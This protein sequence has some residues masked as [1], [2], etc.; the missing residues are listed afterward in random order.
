MIGASA[1]PPQHGGGLDAAEQRWGRHESGWLDLSTGINPHA[2]PL[3]DLPPALWQRLPDREAEAGLLDA[4]RHCYG[5]PAGCPAVAAAGSQ[6]LIGLLPRLIAPTQVL[7]LGPTYA[8]HAYRWRLVGHEVRETDSL[9][10]HPDARIV[11]LANPNNP[12]GRI[13]PPAPLLD[14]ARHLARDNGLLVVD[15]AFA[16]VTPGISLAGQA[17]MPGLLVLRSFGKFFGLAGLRLGVALGE[18]RMIEALSTALG[19]WAASGPALAIG[20]LALADTPWIEA[21]RRRLTVESAA[22]D[23]RLTGLGLERLGGT[24]LFR[25][26]RHARAWELAEGLGAAG[27]LV[28]RFAEQPQ[29]L[30][31]GLAPDKAGTDR[32]IRALERLLR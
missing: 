17:G 28:R 31:I 3:P 11:I 9:P 4:T 2:Y 12:D 10:E 24:D 32:L 23:D 21:M 30:R 22:L 27:V 29:W 6:A 16:D 26:V 13:T 5:A 19:P 8:E 20:R 15:E 25:L 7:V 14:L 18:R 1:A